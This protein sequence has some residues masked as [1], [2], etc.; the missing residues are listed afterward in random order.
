MLSTTMFP[1]Y[2]F[3]G[4]GADDLG[5]QAAALLPAVQMW[6][7]KLQAIPQDLRF[8]AGAQHDLTEGDEPWFPAEA[9]A[10]IDQGQP[11]APVYTN[12]LLFSGPEIRQFNQQWQQIVRL[13]NMGQAPAGA[14]AAIK[15][16][17][18]QLTAS[19]IDQDEPSID[20]GLEKLQAVE[21]RL[22][23]IVQ[24]EPAEPM[25]LIPTSTKGRIWPWLVGFGFVVGVGG[26]VALTR[27]R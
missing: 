10:A 5:A 7:R 11:Y 6:I 24:G 8:R 1:R 16:A 19:P 2:E 26:L 18:L 22:R 20:S 9:R 17:A 14:S 15:Q 27:G 21:K 3:G 23:A 13:L 25:P 12:V 4:F